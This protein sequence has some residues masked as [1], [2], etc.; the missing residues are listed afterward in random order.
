MC[1]F[2]DVQKE[3]SDRF[4]LEQGKFFALWDGYPV[5]KGHAL[6]ILKDHKE[7]FFD[8]SEDE[9]KDAFVLLGKVKELILEK[10]KPDAFNIGVNDGKAA[11]RTIDHLH[12]HLIPRYGGDVNNPKGG[13][14]HVIPGKGDYTKA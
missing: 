4:I 11:G 10:Y 9:M 8:L 3:Q 5:T 12:I 14:R 1:F 13:V 2:C 6:I 7:S